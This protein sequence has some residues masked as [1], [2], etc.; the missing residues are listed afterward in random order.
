MTI[1]EGAHSAS[2]KTIH[3]IRT[4]PFQ[5]R[6]RNIRLLAIV[7][8]ILSAVG[9]GGMLVLAA[10]EFTWQFAAVAGLYALCA[11]ASLL[12]IQVFIPRDRI[13]AGV[14]TLCVAL[15][16]SLT[17]TS[18]FF[19]GMGYPAAFVFFIFTLVGASIIVV[20][21]QSNTLIILGIFT[22]GQSALLSVYSPFEQISI[23]NNEILVPVTLFLLVAGYLTLLTRQMISA[24]L[25]VR[26][27]S[28]FLTIVILPL[29]VLSILLSRFFFSVLSNEEHQSLA[30]AAR[31]TASSVDRLLENQ[32]NAVLE[33]A[34]I[35]VFSR[36]LAL[37]ENERAGSAEENELM[38]ALRLVGAQTAD[39][40]SVLSSIALLDAKGMALQDTAAD[41]MKEGMD[42]ERLRP[43]G[44]DVDQWLQGKPIDEHANDYFR[45]PMEARSTYVSPVKVIAGTRAYYTVSAPVYSAEGK[46]AGVLRARYDAQLLQDMLSTYHGL[47][48]DRSFAIL[49]DDAQIRL[50]DGYTPNFLYR[51]IAPLPDELLLRMQA[52]GRLPALPKEV[53]STSYSEMSRI[54]STYTPE[55]TLFQTNIAPSTAGDDRGQIGAIAGVHSMPWKVI[56]LR[57]DYDDSALRRQQVQLSTM[58]TTIIAML[59]GILAVGTSRVLSQPIVNLTRIAQTI[60]SGDLNAQAPA[61]R[62]DEF[63]QLAAAFNAMTS[64]MRGFITHLEDRVRVRTHE[65]E[66]QNRALSSRA[67]QLKTVSEV[68]RQI[69]SSQEL[70]PL[71][72]SITHMV[73]DRFGFYHVGIFLLDEKQELAVLRAANSEGG[74][75]MLARRHALPVGKVGIV[76]YATGVGQPRIATDVGDDATFFNNP[77]LPE[78]RSEMALPLKA[79][80]YV[81]GALDIQSVRSNDFQPED[82]E[83]F[84][85]L[86][87]QVAIAIYNNRLYT[88]TLRALDEAQAL[89]R[90][91][92][93]SEWTGE[94][95]RRK[96]PGFLYNQSGLAPHQG[97]NPLW[98]KV[99]ASGEPMYAVLPSRQGQPDQAV[100]AVPVTIR[101]ETIGVIHVQDQGENRTWSEDEVAVVNSIA[102]QVAVALENARLF[103][104]TVRRAEREKQVLQIT[105]R[106]RSTN[107]PEEMMQIAI[108]ELQQALRASRTQIYIRQEAEPVTDRSN[109]HE[110]PSTEEGAA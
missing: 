3:N 13:F 84:L 67:Q 53:L 32:Q 44:V 91:Y 8:G 104:N 98:N 33:A 94:V 31:Q 97:E 72:D 92:L 29:I 68:A 96:T 18:A 10:L 12:I 58:V 54:L 38:L 102:G 49:V 35:D 70:E 6:V 85:T 101:G 82:V 66:Q 90:Q 71:L 64:Q 88:Q 1:G 21:W 45:V 39:T 2:T 43:I 27:L 86:A 99:F 89:H 78:T 26:S 19:T 80:G 60:S 56:Y 34:K 5:N 36:Y 50:A 22:S 108:H 15:G 52:E 24:S 79:G 69:V 103:Q 47:L 4:D 74:K 65:I 83:L 55:N 75:R 41:R 46:I 87:D 16:F 106:I 40:G 14:I 109:G 37:P 51:T 81:I 57:T 62:K 100:M 105:A 11:G 61:E 93:R 76:G 20:E 25:R 59:V 28:I 17:G 63:G 107:D 30:A 73:S 42:P 95:A 9:A 110:E 77:D 7:T 48:G 23:P